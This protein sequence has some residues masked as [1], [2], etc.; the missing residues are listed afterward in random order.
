VTVEKLQKK[1]DQAQFAFEIEHLVAH[2]NLTYLEAIV[3]FAEANDLE[4][5]ALG[6]MVK[7]CIP[8]CQKLEAECKRAHLMH[9][10]ASEASLD[11]FL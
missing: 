10:S 2:S 5:E 6:P 3:V 8:I 7:K 11:Q 4:V 9:A 1:F